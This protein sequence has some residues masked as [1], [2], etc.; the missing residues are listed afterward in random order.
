MHTGGPLRD[1]LHGTARAAILCN[2]AHAL[3]HACSPAA[4][5]AMVAHLPSVAA[6]PWHCQ[7]CCS[8]CDA[9]DAVML[10]ANPHDSR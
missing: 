4:G 7:A 8:P 9:L 10:E 6:Q 5:V 1:M 3:L 2:M